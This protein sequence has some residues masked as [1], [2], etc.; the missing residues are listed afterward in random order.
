MQL[1]VSTFDSRTVYYQQNP[2]GKVTKG[3]TMNSR[4]NS[5]K[6][7]FGVVF[8]VM[9]PFL[10]ALPRL[11]KTREKPYELGFSRNLF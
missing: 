11:K 2:D 5:G 1:R 3:E 7:G 4:T 8:K 6:Y 10:E 9:L